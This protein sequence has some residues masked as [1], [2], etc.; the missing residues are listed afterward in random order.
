MCVLD[1]NKIIS[2]LLF[3]NIFIFKLTNT[4]VCGYESKIIIKQ[5]KL[6]IY[7]FF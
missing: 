6:F 3:S 1:G 7:M 2:N 5:I 4:A